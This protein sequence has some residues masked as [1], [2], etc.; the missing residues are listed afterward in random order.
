MKKQ[1]LK[2]KIIIVSIVTAIVGIIVGVFYIMSGKKNKEIFTE[3]NDIIKDKI[4]TND[5]IIK[6]KENEIIEI[7]SHINNNNEK[8][9][10]IKKKKITDDEILN[11]LEKLE[12]KLGL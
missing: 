7:T 1:L 4:N 10:M 5:D 8:I 3:L 11:G 6:E 9:E 12:N 2:I